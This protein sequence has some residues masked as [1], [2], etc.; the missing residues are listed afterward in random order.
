MSSLSVEQYDG[1]GHIIL[2]RIGALNALS[3]EFC[4]EIDDALRDLEPVQKLTT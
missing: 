3:R 4:H 2:N 1:V